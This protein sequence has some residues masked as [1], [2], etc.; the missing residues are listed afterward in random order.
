MPA[1]EELHARIVSGPGQDIR[2]QPRW[3]KTLPEL[4]AEE[5]L[6]Q[7]KSEWAKENDR[8]AF[9]AH[10]CNILSYETLLGG[11]LQGKQRENVVKLISEAARESRA[12]A[13]YTAERITAIGKKAGG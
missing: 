2:L 12:G 10:E 6:V 8:L 1:L 3:I 7:C 13:M 4:L 11:G 9:M 5:G